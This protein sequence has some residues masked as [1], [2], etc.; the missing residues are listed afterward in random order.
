[1]MKR[2]QEQGSCGLW[3]EAVGGFRS[4]TGKLKK[5]IL[6]GGVEAEIIGT[7]THARSLGREP[8]AERQSA[9]CAERSAERW[10]AH[11]RPITS[12]VCSS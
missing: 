3:R 4:G 7:S 9:Y 8:R 5:N 10:T 12:T 11:D 2:L 1:M 6:V